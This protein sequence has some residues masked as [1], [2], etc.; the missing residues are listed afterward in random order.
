M[1]KIVRWLTTGLAV[2]LVTGACAGWD[3]PTALTDLQ[4]VAE[5][6]IEAAR[7]ETFEE[8]E[9]HVHITESGHPLQI[10]QAQ[11]EIEHEAS[12]A[13]RSVAMQ[14]EGEGYA[15]HV[16]FF[17]AGEH[18][19][20]FMGVPHRH[21]LIWELGEH[22]IEAHNAHRIIGPYWVELELSPAPVLEHTAGHIHVHVFER[23]PDGT[24]GAE[25]AGLDVELEV[26]DL[27]GA[28]TTLV[29]TEEAPGEYEGEYS[30]GAAGVYELHVGIDVNGT[31]EEGEFHIPVL[32]PDTGEEPGGGEGGGHGHG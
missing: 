15:A 17:E 30:F 32:S 2:S 8:V 25:V 16:T 14:P 5:F 24:P 20:H 4:P 7:V 13:V 23:L 10:G 31:I 19:L 3:N 21:S 18:H 27:N 28:Q 6:E 1:S 12:G 11:M 9:I 26:H 22:E 29:V